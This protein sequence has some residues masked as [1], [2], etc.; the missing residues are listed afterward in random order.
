MFGSLE[1]GKNE[2]RGVPNKANNIY[3]DVENNPNFKPNIIFHDFP[4]TSHRKVKEWQ[5][6]VHEVRSLTHLLHI[7]N[8]SHLHSRSFSL[9][10][11]SGATTNTR[12]RWHYLLTHLVDT[13]TSQAAS[14]QNGTERDTG[15]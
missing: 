14:H 7:S 9:D 11:Q 5:Q 10:F 6:Y 12:M 2:V 1:N 3:R 8:I 13:C 4:Y 15:K